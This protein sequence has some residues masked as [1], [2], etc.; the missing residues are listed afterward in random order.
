MAYGT[1]VIAQAQTPG[2]DEDLDIVERVIEQAGP[3][4]LSSLVSVGQEASDILTTLEVA[5]VIPQALIDEAR[6]EISA[7][8]GD[9]A[10][11][12]RLLCTIIQVGELD[13]SSAVSNVVAGLLSGQGFDDD[14]SNLKEVTDE[15]TGPIID[16]DPSGSTDSPS[17]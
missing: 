14:L 13:S 9:S 2:A 16:L 17:S 7:P 5:Q 10:L 11:A 4:Y 8:T 6:G 12:N 15:K 1:F 3:A